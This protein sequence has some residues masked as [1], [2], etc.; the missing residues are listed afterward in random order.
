[1]LYRS[2]R[3]W[4]VVDVA[5]IESGG[6]TLDGVT[7]AEFGRGDRLYPLRRARLQAGVQAQHLTAQ[8]LSSS[9][10]F[11]ISEPCDWPSLDSLPTYRD[12]PVLT[13]RTDEG[14][15]PTASYPRLQ[16]QTDYGVA[17]PF[18]QDM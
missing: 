14:D 7:T 8:A 1:L 13:V 12:H 18:V 3:I 16:T 11:D 5:S 9:V 15:A 6:L 4:E 2:A 10:V 17:H